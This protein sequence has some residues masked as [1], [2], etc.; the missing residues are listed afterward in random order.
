MGDLGSIK[1]QAQIAGPEKR[2]LQVLD[3]ANESLPR[4]R[5]T[6]FADEGRLH[7]RDLRHPGL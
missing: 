6:Q 1:K 2:R 5:M 3:W 4:P 7:L